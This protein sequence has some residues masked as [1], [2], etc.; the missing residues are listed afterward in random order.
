M[1]NIIGI[2]GSPK[3]NNGASFSYLKKYTNT[4]INSNLYNTKDIKNIKKSN[5]IILSFPL[6]ID[7]LPS[8]FI[9]FLINL[10]KNNINNKYIY[11]ICNLG[12]YE[13]K[14]ANIALKII[15]NF[16]SRT[17]N[18]YMGGLA[19]GGGPCGYLKY[20]IINIKINH[21]LKKLKN[22]ILNKQAFEDKYASL[23]LPRYIYLK[24]ANYNF[25]KEIKKYLLK[26]KTII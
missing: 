5:I 8:H 1:S 6:Y 14:Q 21:Y 15:K 9:K 25:K 10:E 19:I 11:V 12:F 26:N 24:C 20:P 3:I 7:C 13:G 2:N 17:N 23:L 22:N 18:N 4:I 16:C